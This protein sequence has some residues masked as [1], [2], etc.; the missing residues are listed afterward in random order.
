[1]EKWLESGG[2]SG[3]LGYPL[4]HETGVGDGRGRFNDFLGGAIYWTAATGARVMQSVPLDIWRLRG[5]PG[6]RWG[7]AEF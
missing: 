1:M 2:V 5:G 7:C 3:A 4:G 6:S